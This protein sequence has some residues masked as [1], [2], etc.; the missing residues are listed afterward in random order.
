MNKK[1]L[2]SALLLLFIS[3]K[4]IFAA[5][6]LPVENIE[7]KDDDTKI[8]PP[9]NVEVKNGK[10]KGG[11]NKKDDYDFFNNLSDTE[12][13]YQ[14]N[15]QNYFSFYP[16]YGINFLRSSKDEDTKDFKILGSRTLGGTLSINMPIQFY[17]FFWSIAFDLSQRT[18]TWYDFK[19]LHTKS[20]FVGKVEGDD[21]KNF[22][23]VLLDGF[24]GDVEFTSLNFFDFS[25]MGQAGFKS[26]V[27]DH[28][29][30]FFIKGMVGIGF[31]FGETVEYKKK[32][33]LLD[34]QTIKN[35]PMQNV[36]VM[37]G[38]ETGYWR[39]GV[40]FVSDYIPTF[41]KAEKKYNGEE[42]GL[43][44]EFFPMTLSLFFDLL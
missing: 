13:K 22:N 11:R 14:E 39:I 18:L 36:K 33:F 29:N 41:K 15:P 25:V 32:D 17:N 34:T 3:T 35:V 37:W 44:R 40:R 8:V 19:N 4:K 42:L 30:G 38:F 9:E 16:H 10:E 27:Y 7:L 28:R 23:D 1:I 21:G 5:G 20:L 43:S 26:D 2:T 24:K 6:T 31:Q 12:M